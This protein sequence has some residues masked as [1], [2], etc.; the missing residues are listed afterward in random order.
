MRPVFA[1]FLSLLTDVW[2][3][4]RCRHDYAEQCDP[5]SCRLCGRAER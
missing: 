2:H 5:P 3:T 4:W 1:A